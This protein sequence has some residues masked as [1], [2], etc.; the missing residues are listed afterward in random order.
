MVGVKHTGNRARG[1]L[2][3][4]NEESRHYHK[5]IHFITP[6][7]R[8]CLVQVADHGRSPLHCSQTLHWRCILF[9]SV[10]IVTRRGR[11]GMC[12]IVY[13]LCYS[14]RPRRPVPWTVALL[15]ICFFALICFMAC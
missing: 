14:S 4:R 15:W 1:S 11:N 2:R 5:R 8:S 6:N 3:G 13:R 7:V 9:V 10:D 12:L